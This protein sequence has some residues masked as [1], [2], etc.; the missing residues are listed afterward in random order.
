ML[1][2][3]ALNTLLFTSL[4][5]ASGN[6]QSEECDADPDTDC[7][8][9]D[10][11]CGIPLNP[12]GQAV[13]DTVSEV[14]I[15][16][17]YYFYT[18]GLDTS[19]CVT[20]YTYFGQVNDPRGNRLSSLY[21]QTTTFYLIPG[22]KCLGVYGLLNF[23]T[24]GRRYSTFYLPMQKDPQP[25]AFTILHADRDWEFFH[26]CG[27]ENTKTGICDKPNL[28]VKTRLFPTQLP[29]GLQES[30]K[31]KIN[32]ILEPWCMS[33]ADMNLFR[34]D[35]T[36]PPQCLTTPPEDFATLIDDGRKWVIKA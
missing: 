6:A 33:M 13:V 28:F 24:N 1:L 11:P 18:P 4:V 7:A 8:A 17:E 14:G 32:Q 35:K 12:P 25:L 21:N 29:K 22:G 34:E 23:T 3:V 10:Q 36:V 19:N 20:N 26:Y 9:P 5:T 2:A 15:W 31:D 27:E 16:Y 30:I